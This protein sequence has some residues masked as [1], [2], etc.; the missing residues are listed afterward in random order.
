[1]K[2]CYRHSGL[3]ATNPSFRAGRA[4][5]LCTLLKLSQGHAAFHLLNRPEAEDHTFYASHGLGSRAVLTKSEAFKRQITEGTAANVKV[6][7][8]RPHDGGAAHT[9]AGVRKPPMEETA[10]G[11]RM[12]PRS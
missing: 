1:M 11:E 2:P 5:Y 7:G 10:M 9:G 12:M 8:C 4:F 6:C 3:S